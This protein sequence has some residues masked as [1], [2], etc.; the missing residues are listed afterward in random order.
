MYYEG[1]GVTKDVA[2]AR[3]MLQEAIARGN[4]DATKVL[5][6]IDAYERTRK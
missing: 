5:K 1:I 3:R 2:M 6:E 4:S